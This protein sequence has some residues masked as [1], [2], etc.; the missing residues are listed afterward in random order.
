M[1]QENNGSNTSLLLAFIAGAAVGA[2]VVALTTPKSGKEVREDLKSLGKRARS[3]L[4]DVTDDAGEIWEE[5]KE[6][7]AQAAA[8][9]KRGFQDAARDLKG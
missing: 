1:S 2:L 7:T 8:D 6:R 4:G 3:K 5:A 9:L